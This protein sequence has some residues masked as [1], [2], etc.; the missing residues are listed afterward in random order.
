VEGLRA[1]LDVVGPQLVWMWW[2]PNPFGRGGPLSVWTCWV[3]GLALR[4]GSQ[5][6]FG[7]GGS[8]EMCGR[9]GPQSLFGRGGSTTCMDV[10]G[11]KPVWTRWAFVCLDVVDF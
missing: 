11:P 7:C 3:P 8:Q 9:G 6:M 4:A 5:N 1:C 10:V 2:V